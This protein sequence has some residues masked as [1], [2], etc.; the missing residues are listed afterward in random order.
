MVGGI[1]QE[2]FGKVQ[3]HHQ[4]RVIA[5]FDFGPLTHFKAR[6]VQ[7]AGLSR[8]GISVCTFFGKR[9]YIY[10]R[11]EELKVP[12]EGSGS[13]L[14]SCDCLPSNHSVARFSACGT[15]PWRN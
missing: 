7:L 6:V 8:E 5:A 10:F 11:I 12:N 4:S 13:C 14:T 9:M 1:S 15:D 3:Q 2:D